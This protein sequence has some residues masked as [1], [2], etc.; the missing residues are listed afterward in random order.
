MRA[1]ARAGALLTISALAILGAVPTVARAG[2]ATVTETF[3]TPG[4]HLFTVP[5]GVTELTVL[6]DGA[7]GGAGFENAAP[8]GLGGRTV[9]VIEVVPGEVLQINVAAQGGAAPA[10][11]VGGTGGSGGA[12]GD[13]SGGTGG[14]SPAQGGAGAGGGGGGSSDVRASPYALS[15]RLLAAGGGGG[16]GGGLDT[17]G[18]GPF[19]GQAGGDGGGTAGVDGEGA[20]ICGAPPPP[21]EGGG[22]ATQSGPGIGCGAADDGELGLGGDGLTSLNT[23]AGQGGGGG[24]G[25]LY[26]GGGGFTNDSPGGGGGGGGSGLCTGTCETFAAGVQAGDGVVTITYV[27]PPDPPAPTPLVPLV[28]EPRFTG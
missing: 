12:S 14:A 26:G 7:A 11:D 15:D 20:S 27:L 10:V 23:G 21:T 1:G 2:A 5:A 18:E 28:V 6:V 3:A 22:G 17:G 4:T 8:A 13:A 9:S 16:A 19:D 24:G 25:G